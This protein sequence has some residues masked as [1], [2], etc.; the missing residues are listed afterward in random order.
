L[1]LATLFLTP[2]TACSDDDDD[3]SSASTDALELIG[4]DNRIAEIHES[5][6]YNE[7]STDGDITYITYNDDNRVIET[8]IGSSETETFTYNSD[9]QLTGYE[10]SDEDYPDYDYSYEISWSGSTAT[11]E[12]TEDDATYEYKFIFNS[13]MQLQKV[14]NYFSYEGEDYLYGYSDYTW[15][16]NNLTKI[17]SYCYDSDYDYDMVSSQNNKTSLLKPAIKIDPDQLLLKSSD[18]MSVYLETTYTYDSKTNPLRVYPFAPFSNPALFSNNNITE[19]SEAYSYDDE[20]YTNVYEYTYTYN[21]DDMPE[22]QTQ[23]LFDSWLYVKTY[24]YEAVE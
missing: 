22:T 8:T 12:E 4:G 21:T 3:D 14:E 1:L 7:D 24:V 15:S 5:Q 20:D 11:I 13:D 19:I 18:E 6:I 2:F 23:T 16:S 9:D 17:T 10:Y